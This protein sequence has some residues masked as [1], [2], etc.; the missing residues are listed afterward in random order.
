MREKHLVSICFVCYNR[1]NYVGDALKSLFDQTYSPLE[2]CISDNCSTDG[3]RE[4][5]EKMIADYRASGGPHSIVYNTNPTNIGGSPNI[6]KCYRMA[7]G[8]LLVNAHDDDVSHPNRVEEIVKAWEKS[9]CSAGVVVHAYNTMDVNGRVYGRV[10]DFN[11]WHGFCA[12]ETY[13]RKTIT[14]FPA[15]IVG[16]AVEDCVFHFRGLMVGE[17]A[18]VDSPLLD[19]RMGVGISSSGGD[20]RN[21]LIWLIHINYM[22]IKQALID[23]EFYKDKMKDVRY[24]KIRAKLNEIE[25]AKGN[26]IFQDFPLGLLDGKTFSERWKCYRQ[27]RCFYSFPFPWKPRAF[28]YF[29]SQTFCL[30]RG[31]LFD[32]L[33]DLSF[34]CNERL[35][36]MRGVST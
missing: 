31:T 18:F 12:M 27:I 4:L 6:M 28:L 23:L 14:E 34:T 22:A 19:Y 17:L 21:R 8:A 33:F 5:V 13:T 20:V 1:V 36:R 16:D 9:G 29:L 2:I 24:E 3:T 30:F 32:K 7:H 25:E 10:S 11:P 26:N 15:V 35:C